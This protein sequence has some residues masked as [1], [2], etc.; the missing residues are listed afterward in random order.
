MI[1]EVVFLFKDISLIHV[2]IKKYITHIFFE[3][4]V[5]VYK[6][7]SEKTWK[8]IMN[9]FHRN[10]EN[11]IYDKINETIEYSNSAV[12]DIK[13]LQSIE[14]KMPKSLMN[15]LNSKYFIILNKFYEEINIFYEEFQVRS[16][17]YYTLL[18]M[19]YYYW[20]NFSH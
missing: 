12:N 17:Y 3:L 16:Y 8:K 5:D 7:F 11:S 10:F 19:Y 1:P 20:L 13:M 2:F 15:V 6:S 18:C 9:Q 4:E 14:N